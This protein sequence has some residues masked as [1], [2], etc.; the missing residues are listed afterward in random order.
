MNAQV[1]LCI[2]ACH[3]IHVLSRGSSGLLYH[4]SLCMRYHSN[5]ICVSFT[6]DR[7]ICIIKLESFLSV[8]M[9]PFF[10]VVVI[11]YTVAENERD[12][13]F[14][15]TF[16]SY[17]LFPFW[18]SQ[19]CFRTRT[20]TK[21]IFIEENIIGFIFKSETMRSEREINRIIYTLMSFSCECVRR[22][23][24]SF[25]VR[26]RRHKRRG[27][28]SVWMSAASMHKWVKREKMSCVFN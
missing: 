20:H 24:L 14:I 26:Q 22:D 15:S 3:Y 28:V 21:S 5:G 10:V 1:L 19:C 23:F 11:I 9:L 18:C 7:L 25:T 12:C 27:F 16:F 8:C 2:S 4:F 17:L 13:F 6:R